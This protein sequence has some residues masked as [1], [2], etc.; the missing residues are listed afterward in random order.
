MRKWNTL[1]SIC[2]IILFLIHAVAGGF[3]LMGLL[4]GG[5]VILSVL[6]KIMLVFIIIHGVIGIKL[7]WDSIAACK[8]SGVSYYKENRLFWA[9]RISGFAIIIFILIHVILFLGKNDGVYRLNYFGT[10]QLATQILMVLSLAVHI[11]TNINPMIISFGVS[12]IKEYAVDI[13]VVLSAILLFT[14]V[15]FVIYYIRWIIW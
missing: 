4:S 14:A 5:N 2:I 11:I 1:L 12:K 8:K 7:T 13:L 15:G 6:A 3:Q 9:R 10:L